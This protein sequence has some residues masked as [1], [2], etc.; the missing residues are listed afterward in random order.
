M[1]VRRTAQSRHHPLAENPSGATR[2][3]KVLDVG[4]LYNASCGLNSQSAVWRTMATL[5]E[6]SW[7]NDITDMLGVF[8]GAPA[9]TV[10]ILKIIDRGVVSDRF[11][12]KFSKLG[13]IMKIVKT[14]T[15]THSVHVLDPLFFTLSKLN[16]ITIT[17]E[18]KDTEMHYKVADQ[19]FETVD[20]IIGYLKETVIPGLSLK[21]SDII[22]ET[23]DGNSR[24][25]AQK[26]LDMDDCVVSGD[27]I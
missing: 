19:T 16:D 18:K 11:E 3:R 23:S 8:T 15:G 2:L 26:C 17:I 24:C 7:T 4:T 12:C 6:R 25:R 14:E 1:S 9:G 20:A 5:D 10:D 13:M 27:N 21:F 22:F